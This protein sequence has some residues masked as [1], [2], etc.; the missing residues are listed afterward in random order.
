M[1]RQCQTQSIFGDT[2]YSCSCKFRLVT[3]P[4]LGLRVRKFLI[5]TTLDRWKRHFREQ[6]YIENYF[7]LLKST[8]STKTTSQ[9]CWRNIWANLFGRPYWSNGI[10]TRL[11]S[12]MEDVYE[13]V[14][15]LWNSTSRDIETKCGVIY[16]WKVGGNYA[17]SI[18]YLDSCYFI[19]IN[20]ESIWR[21]PKADS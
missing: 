17:Y 5:L 14:G 16:S 8:K 4:W 12:P 21:K 19:F 11:G 7:Y 1:Q 6:N 13:A 3:P 9:K 20:H 15:G 2:V 10:K 18:V